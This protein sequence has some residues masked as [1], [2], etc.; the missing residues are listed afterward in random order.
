MPVVCLLPLVLMQRSLRSAVAA[1]LPGLM[2][3]GGGYGP[4]W[5]WDSNPSGVSVFFQKWRSGSP[6]FPILDSH[7]SA[8]QSAFICLGLALAGFLAVSLWSVDEA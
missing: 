2:V 5:Q 8:W 6:L 1:L 3:T 7:F 4:A